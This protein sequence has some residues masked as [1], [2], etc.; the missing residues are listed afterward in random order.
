MLD[1]DHDFT[2]IRSLL[3]Q[4]LYG[5]QIV[6]CAKNK[7]LYR[8]GDVADA[9]YYLQEGSLMFTTL[10]HGGKAAVVSVRTKGEVIGQSVLIGRRRRGYTAT[11][12]TDA[13]LT[14]IDL[15]AAAKLMAAYPDFT[16]FLLASNIAK[17]YRVQETMVDHIVHTSEARLARLLLR[18]ADT[19]DPKH[20]PAAIPQVS[21]ERLAEMIG[22]TRGR[23]N[24]FLNR[25]RRDGLI[26][27]ETP[28]RVH[29]RRVKSMLDKF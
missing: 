9:F 1:L 26:E 20:E 21:Q 14:R 12:L 18:L 25:F 11:A 17:H 2:K 8:Q 6:N 3:K 27:Y 29:R 4:P 10:T 24:M 13:I 5:L 22:T 28:I 19:N 23:V 7:R 15:A 16:K